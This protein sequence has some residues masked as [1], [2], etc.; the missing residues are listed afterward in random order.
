L[1]VAAAAGAVLKLQVPFPLQP[2]CFFNGQ[3]APLFIRSQ[4][5]ILEGAD[6]EDATGRRKAASRSAA[7][8]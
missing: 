2:P 8:R 5:D 1:T 6:S 4:H 3:E 7:R